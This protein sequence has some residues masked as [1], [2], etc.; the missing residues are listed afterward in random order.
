M[1]LAENPEKPGFQVRFLSIV[2][3]NTNHQSNQ[4]GISVR[5]HYT[6]PSLRSRNRSRVTYF[7]SICKP[8]LLKCASFAGSHCNRDNKEFTKRCHLTH[9]EVF[10]N[11]T[12]PCIVAN[13]GSGVSILKKLSRTHYERVS[14]SSVGDGTY[15]VLCR[16][17]TITSR[18]TIA[19]TDFDGF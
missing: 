5:F 11:S 7:Q 12:H 17:L 2:H 8:M 13:I 14:G 15:R 3:S 1:F 19:S 6:F 4:R 18:I 16:S 10:N 9:E